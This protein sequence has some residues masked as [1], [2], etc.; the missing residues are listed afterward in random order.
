MPR[1]IRV[2]LWVACGLAMVS[3]SAAQ[4]P[5]ATPAAAAAT[6]NGQPIT[7]VAVQRGLKRVPPAEHAKARPEILNYLIDNLL[8]D[9]HLTAQKTPV[10][11]KEVEARVT[12]LKTEVKKHG[13]DY[14]KMLSELMLTEAELRSQ[15][16]ADLRWE[17][18][19]TA[20]GTD[21]ALND[22]FSKH[23]EMFDG[24]MVR[25]RHILLTPAGDPK[26]VE[27]AVAQLKQVKAQ[28][29]AQVTAEVAKL[30][31]NADPLARD[32]ARC[33]RLADLFGERAAKLSCCPSKA[34]GGDLNWFP[35]AGSMV[36]PFAAAAFALKPGQMSDPVQTPFGYHLILVTGRKPGAPTEFKDVKDEVREVFC[37][38]LRDSLVA[39]LRPKAQIVITP[40]K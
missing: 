38:R 12:E 7:E 29:E 36:E 20:Q 27:Q 35:R 11:P 13:Q 2:G 25:A 31:D 4:P 37:Q 24:S 32:Q 22:L 26:S 39:Q 14:D 16:A 1:F 17:K 19:A 30:P 33:Q 21:A 8:I 15:M 3:R 10:D 18:Y 40:V 28:L 9:Q 6:V 34:D 23:P 5:A